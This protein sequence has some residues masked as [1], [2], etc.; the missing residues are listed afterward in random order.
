[1]KSISF[2]KSQF[3]NM[4]SRKK[5][6]ALLFFDSTEYLQNEYKIYCTNKGSRLVEE[7]KGYTLQLHKRVYKFINQLETPQYLF[8]SVK[9]KSHIDNAKFHNGNDYVVA[10]D[11]S[12][13]FPK[14]SINYVYKFFRYKLN[15]SHT[16][17]RFLSEITTIDITKYEL[18]P[19]V[20]KWYSIANEKL[21][22][23]VPNVHVPTGSCLSQKL[24]FLSYIDMFNEIYDYC[25]QNNIKMSVYVDDIVISSKKKISKTFV[26]KILYIFSKYGQEANPKKIKYYKKGMYKKIT[27]IYINEDNQLKAPSKQHFDIQKLRVLVDR[28]RSYDKIESLVGKLRYVST[29]ESGKFK[30]LIKKYSNMKNAK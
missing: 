27:G 19:T 4:Q 10:L 2:D 29:L 14:C 25:N 16:N 17:A 7:P 24:A 13:F 18:N 22:Y 12:K 21:K 11:L 5:L 9:G 26:K 8:S 15:M 6:N 23:S 30:Q 28:D 20:Q 1:M 3:Y